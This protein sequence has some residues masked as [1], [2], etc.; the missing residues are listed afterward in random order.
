MWK[1]KTRA[2]SWAETCSAPAKQETVHNHQ[3]QIDQNVKLS[4]TSITVEG[5]VSKWFR[6]RTVKSRTCPKWKHT[7]EACRR[8][9][10]TYT[11]T[12]TCTEVNV[13][14]RMLISPGSLQSWETDELLW[15]SRQLRTNAVD[16]WS[17][18]I[19]REEASLPGLRQLLQTHALWQPLKNGHRS[20]QMLQKQFLYSLTFL[21]TSLPHL[22]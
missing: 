21:L 9:Q 13:L 6:I 20:K 16:F 11:D 10:A 4:P 1:H 12:H 22:T 8:M 18:F 15:S 5:G 2:Q 17:A 3:N 7:S 19:P 14:H